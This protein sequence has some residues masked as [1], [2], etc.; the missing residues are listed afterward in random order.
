MK[1]TALTSSSSVSLLLLAYPEKGDP[2]SGMIAL[3]SS[4]FSGV[5][6]AQACAAQTERLPGNPALWPGSSGR[7]LLNQS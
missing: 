3:P 2:N 5:R 7:R 6:L 4:L 1:R